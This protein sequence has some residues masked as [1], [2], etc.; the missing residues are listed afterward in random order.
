MI[1]R[2]LDNDR[3][4]IIQLGLDPSQEEEFISINQTG[5]FMLIDNLPEQPE[6]GLNYR[7]DGTT[8]VIDVQANESEA[9][10]NK[11]L[12]YKNYLNDTDFKMTSDYDQDV[13]EVLELRTEAREFIRVNTQE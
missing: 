7:W 9:V 4:V 5:G 13:T 6:M 2:K 10:I 8:V 12:K 1:V 11:I 3:V